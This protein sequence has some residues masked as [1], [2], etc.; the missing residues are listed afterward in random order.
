M[1]VSRVV[2]VTMFTF[3]SWCYLLVPAAW[4]ALLWRS[5][6]ALVH[7]CNLFYANALRALLLIVF[8]GSVSFVA[9]S[10]SSTW[11]HLCVAVRAQSSSSN[12]ST[13]RRVLHASARW[14]L[15]IWAA[16]SGLPRRSSW[17]PLLNNSLA[18]IR[19]TFSI[20]TMFI[21]IYMDGILFTFD[22]LV[23]VTSSFIFVIVRVRYFGLLFWLI[24]LVWSTLWL[25]LAWVGCLSWLVA[26]TRVRVLLLL[27]VCDFLGFAVSVVASLLLALAVELV[28]SLALSVSQKLHASGAHLALDGVPRA[29]GL[30][31]LSSPLWLVIHVLEF[32]LS[33]S[34]L[35]V[36]VLG[37]GN[38]SRVRTR[39][40]F[41][42]TSCRR[43]LCAWIIMSACSHRP[44]TRLSVS[45]S[46]C[47]T[48]NFTFWWF[49]IIVLIKILLLYFALLACLC[50]D[51][52]FNYC[53]LFVAFYAKSWLHIVCHD[54]CFVAWFA[55]PFLFLEW[56][57]FF[58][59]FFVQEALLLILQIELGGFHDD[60]AQVFN[61][62]EVCFAFL[63]VAAFLAIQFV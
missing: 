27:D 29:L 54:V 25:L 20:F 4:R 49:V 22:T 36:I 48:L 46:S 60:A 17:L 43:R 35:F 33:S 2:N 12:L 44:T 61:E 21:I 28:T 51:H 57:L 31:R 58:F 34:I 15:T 52:I 32:I 38:C 47:A 53:I 39:A 14:R 7:D 45:T 30:R 5:R 13:V 16:S 37:L 26:L 8:S 24:M 50:M 6:F 55:N 11:V 62:A 63:D 18:C 1:D 42:L 40:I 19:W 3:C 10:T 23:I 59:L 9:S 56:F 41:I